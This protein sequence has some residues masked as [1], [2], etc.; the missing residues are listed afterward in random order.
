MGTVILLIF[1]FLGLK[2]KEINFTNIKYFFC[3]KLYLSIHLLLLWS[4]I[5][6][7]WAADKNIYDLLRIF[8]T[9]YLSILFFY[10]VKKLNTKES[11]ILI[12]VICYTLLFL[13]ITLIFEAISNSAIHKIIRPSDTIPRDG[14]WVPY[15]EILSARGT[16][17]LASFSILS[18]ILII[19][20][21]KRKTL[22]VLYIVLSTVTCILMPMQASLLSVCV[23]AIIFLIS[24]YYPKLTIRIIF[25]GLIFGTFLAPWVSQKLINEK[26]DFIESIEIDRGLKQRLIIW[27]YSSKLIAEKPIIGHGF[28]SSRY[29]STK[30]GYYNNTNWSNLPLHPHNLW[31]QIWLELGLVGVLVFC[32]FLFS[33]Y[34]SILRYNFSTLDICLINSSIASI[35]VLSLVSFGVWQFWWISSI[36]I[37]FGCINI[38][39]NIK[40]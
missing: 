27:G 25:F 34:Q 12:Y 39:L 38:K 1:P 3:N 24:N 37:L 35:T 7:I 18:A 21:T 11:K 17:I 29:L 31:L 15:I 30:S 4:L 13:L 19:Q 5:T 16:S 36:G 14:E 2:I 8:S 6:L 28:D 23:G 33:I 9:I 10:S 40:K 20:I 32:A 26:T 22:G